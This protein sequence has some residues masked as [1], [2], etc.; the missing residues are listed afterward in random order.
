LLKL[1]P[2]KSGQNTQIVLVLTLLACFSQPVSHRNKGFQPR[3]RQVSQ[4]AFTH[5]FDKDL[6]ELLFLSSQIVVQ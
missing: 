4:I 6:L 5:L 3:V 1:S 2:N